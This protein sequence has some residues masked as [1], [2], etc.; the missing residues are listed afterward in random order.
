AFNFAGV[1]ADPLSLINGRN[2]S[3]G[4][5]PLDVLFID[6]THNAKS[7]IWN[8][9]DGSPDTA[10]T[11]YVVSH[12]YPNP[13]IYTVMMVAIDSNTCNVA[14]TAYRHV[15]ART[16]RAQVDFSFTKDPGA[17]C[18][19]LD[20]D[21][22]NT[23]VPPPGKPFGANSFTWDFGDNTGQ[24]KDG[25]GPLNHSFA[26]PGTYVINLILNDTSYCNFPDTAIHALR[27]SPLAKA[28]FIT[29][30]TGCAP[31]SAVF[32]NTSLGGVTFAWD[33]GDPASGALNASTDVNPV[34]LYQNPGAYTVTLHEQD[35]STC[36]VVSD[37]SF[38][39]SVS[40]KPSAAF[41][42]APSP[43][44]ANVP[45]VFTN[46]SE[47]GVSYKWLF[48]DGDSTVTNSMDTVKHLYNSTDTFP[49]CL[50]T[51]N[52]YGCIDTACQPVAA[53][54]NPLL[55][56][57]NAFTPGRFGANSVLKVMGFG[58]LRMDFRIYN[59]W[60]KLVFESDNPNVGWDGN[61]LGTPQPMDVYAYTL[62]A[63]FSNGVHI[64][65][66][67]DITLVR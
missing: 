39:I 30:A 9:G 45:I 11:S 28:Q 57:P 42:Y 1:V 44:V 46:G 10:T 7:Y 12:T 26:A 51:T 33:F 29:P 23:S 6:N 22:T 50:L 8:F 2:D 13:G 34:H 64:T 63:E 52:Q 20:Y 65:K 56:V 58:I 55:D 19:S 36:N 5:V 25:A 59:R 27:V 15:I 24:V 54:I 48:G 60:G 41:A 49:A 66:K 43:P 16:D 53:L 3:S 31:Y 40:V 38:T 18:T 61:Y 37:T 14:D 32:N 47:G 67:G 17:P 21:F 35:P 62:E 4:C